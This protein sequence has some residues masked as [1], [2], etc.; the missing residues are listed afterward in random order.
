MP[1]GSDRYQSVTRGAQSFTLEIPE[2]TPS[3]EKSKFDNLLILEFGN[4]ALAMR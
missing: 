2:I 1:T 3:I 4:A